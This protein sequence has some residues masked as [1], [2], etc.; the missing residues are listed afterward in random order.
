MPRGEE[1]VPERGGVD[2]PVGATGEEALV[3]PER[4]AQ[5]LV[6]PVRADAME[7]IVPVGAATGSGLRF[8]A[9]Q[10]VPVREGERG[11]QSRTHRW[12]APQSRGR[13]RAIAS[14][15]SVSERR[16]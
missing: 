14:S 12:I 4:V 9:L 13:A 5:E 11:R 10:Q 16:T 8:R 1:L 3:H 15:V 7:R 2:L 6:P